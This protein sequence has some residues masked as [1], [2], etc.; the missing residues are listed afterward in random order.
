MY[1]L[2]AVV[3]WSLAVGISYFF[4][5]VLVRVRGLLSE[6]FGM[7]RELRERRRVQALAHFVGRPLTCFTTTSVLNTEFS[8]PPRGTFEGRLNR[9][10][11]VVATT[12]WTRLALGIR[13][14]WTMLSVGADDCTLG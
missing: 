11:R 6:Q 14:T 7:R 8:G 4:D 1:W 9:P 5:L 3:R 12:A 2:P 10:H 13:Q